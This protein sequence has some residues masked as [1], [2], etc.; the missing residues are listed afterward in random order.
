[1]NVSANKHCRWCHRV[2]TFFNAHHPARLMFAF[3]VFIG[4]N[5]IASVIQAFAQSGGL[6]SVASIE[7]TYIVQLAIRYPIIFYPLSLLSIALAVFGWRLDH[8]AK[9]RRKEEVA[10]QISRAAGEIISPFIQALTQQLKQGVQDDWLPPKDI[11]VLPLPPHASGL[12]GR[13]TEQEW[14]K[15]RLLEGKTTGVWAFAG[16]GGVGKTSLVADLLPKMVEEFPG[17]IGVIRANEITDPHIIIRQ[18]V[19]KFVPIWPGIARAWRSD[20]GSPLFQVS[21]YHV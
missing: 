6:P 20:K 9:I 19:E 5:T 14:L 18:L 12:V 3:L 8:Q 21:F 1:M 10:R 16:M 11:A 4:L 17:G 15:A 2:V 13:V 7:Q